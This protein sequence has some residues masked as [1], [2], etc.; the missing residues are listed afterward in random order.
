[1]VQVKFMSK[2]MILE[3]NENRL[4]KVIYALLG[5]LN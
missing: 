4:S 5:G 3:K 1:M 2:E